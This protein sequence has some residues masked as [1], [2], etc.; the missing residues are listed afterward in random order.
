M[1]VVSALRTL[2][3]TT[4]FHVSLVRDRERMLAQGMEGSATTTT[5]TTTQPRQA[6]L[7]NGN[8]DGEDGD[9]EDGEDDEGGA[10]SCST[11]CSYS[12]ENFACES[13]SSLVA[14]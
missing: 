1:S 9:G 10:P 2:E 4:A 5:T 13:S 12:S 7:G 6:G 8:E 3:A 14:I 11:T